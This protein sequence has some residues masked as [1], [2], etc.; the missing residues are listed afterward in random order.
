MGR[1]AALRCTIGRLFSGPPVSPVW[2]RTRTQAQ[3]QITCPERTRFR[4]PTR[5]ANPFYRVRSRFFC[6]KWTIWVGIIL[7]AYSAKKAAVLDQDGGWGL[8]GLIPVVLYDD[9]DTINSP[10]AVSGLGRGVITLV[11]IVILHGAFD[12]WGDSAAL[13][14]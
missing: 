5:R 12:A 11:A 6:G 10:G 2:P 13:G 7:K 8:E 14:A 3:S 4:S 1:V 9:C